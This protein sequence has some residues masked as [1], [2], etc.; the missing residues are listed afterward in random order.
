MFLKSKMID[1]ATGASP[2]WSNTKEVASS[3][4]HDRSIIELTKSNNTNDNSPTIVQRKHIA[5]RIICANEY[6][7]VNSF[8]KTILKNKIL[9]ICA[10]NPRLVISI[11]INEILLRIIFLFLF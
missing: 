5:S 2:P 11:T 3:P 10:S 1:N 6:V 4:F 7:F 8:S 9:S